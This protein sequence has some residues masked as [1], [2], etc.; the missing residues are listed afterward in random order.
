MSTTLYDDHKRNYP[1]TIVIHK[2]KKFLYAANR[3]HNTITL[4][5]I[6][7]N[8]NYIKSFSCKGETPRDIIIDPTGNYL[9]VAN[10]DTNTVDIFNIDDNNGYLDHKYTYTDNKSPSCLTFI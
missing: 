5:Y 9:F 6:K 3:G 8:L 10:Q 1:S 4:F 7:N 2:N